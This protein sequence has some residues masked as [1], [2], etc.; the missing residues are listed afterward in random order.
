MPHVIDAPS[1]RGRGGLGRGHTSSHA[2]LCPD[3]D[4]M[5][6]RRNPEQGLPAGGAVV[7]MLGLSQFE[8]RLVLIVDA[9]V[10]AVWP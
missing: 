1:G 8:R 2:A 7:P 9:R 6:A 5:R 3:N 4:P 10:S